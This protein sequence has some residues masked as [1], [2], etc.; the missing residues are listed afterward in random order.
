MVD[1]RTLPAGEGNEVVRGTLDDLA[2][3]G[4]RR[5]IAAA[6]EAEVEEYVGS[7]AGEVGADGKRLV[8][9]NGRAR[10]RRVTVG[11]GTVPV[12]AP[13]VNDKRV[14]EE[15]GERRRFSSRILPA[16]ARR[17]PKVTEVLPVLYLHGLSTGDFGPALRDLLGED[18]SGLSPSSIQRLTES[19]QAE[20]AAFGQR[21]LRF[22]QYAYW[23]VDGVHVSVRLG[24]DDRLCLLVV[25][26]V[27][28]DGVKELLAV[29][30]GY[31]ESTESWAGV[32]RDLKG[33]G[34]NEP[35]LV[36]GDGA[37]GTWAALRDVYPGAR[38]QACWVH[39]IANV[40]DCL[41]KRLQPRAKSLLH[42]IMEAPTRGD[43][44]RALER[45][46]EDLAAK[47][48]KAIAKLDRDWQHL[49]AF[50]DF[51]AEHWRHLRTSNAIESSF[52]T[53]KLRT[54]VTKGAG[55][56]K[57]A[58]AMAFKLLDAAQQRWRRFN[59]HELVADVLT[60]ARFNDGIRVTDDNRH[61]DKAEDEKVAA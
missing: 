45:L 23:F 60:G 53:V 38:R 47:Y 50:Y 41:P 44:G 16:Y 14:E 25:I 34:A 22:H 42:E 57:A 58:L 26:G 43:A 36:V 49:T 20:H 3:E 32:M 6:L 4:A 56:K 61:N 8:V 30:D 9:R 37:L 21:E 19:W 48:P 35:Q 5:M 10:E 55:S 51:P 2:R 17:S 39:A 11:S 29:E 52:A 59:G 40:L 7:L 1:V 33:R 28:E 31:R 24:E 46:R 12:R 15:T 27:R 54:R 18:A 13:R